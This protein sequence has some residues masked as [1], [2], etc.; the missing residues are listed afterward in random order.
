MC[1][2]WMVVVIFAWALGDRIVWNLRRLPWW[3]VHK[4]LIP[5]HWYRYRHT[6]FW[7]LVLYVMIMINE[8]ILYIVGLA[9]I[10]HTPWRYENTA[11]VIF[12]VLSAAYLSNKFYDW[13]RK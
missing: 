2:L 12:V 8:G 10:N 4:R 5:W 3:R 11:V 7:T 13:I 6:L 9:I 1:G